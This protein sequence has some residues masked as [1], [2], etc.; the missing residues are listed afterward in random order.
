[1]RQDAET[2]PPYK[3]AGNRPLY[4]LYACE[5]LQTTD[6]PVAD[7]AHKW[8]A[9]WKNSKDALQRGMQK[10]R[11]AYPADPVYPHLGIVYT[12]L[13]DDVL[14]AEMPVDTMKRT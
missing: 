14:E 1:M 6:I 10:L 12:R 5:F 3:S 2:A 8:D 11:S 13:G 9:D 7:I 4:F